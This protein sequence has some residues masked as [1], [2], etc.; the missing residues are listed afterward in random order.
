MEKIAVADHRILRA[1]GK[2]VGGIGT[3]MAEHPIL[4]LNAIVLPI[5]AAKLYSD[6]ATGIGRYHADIE[7]NN[8][9]RQNLAMQQQMINQDQ[10][11]S[12]PIRRNLIMQPTLM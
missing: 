8:L 11:T 12:N 10:P 6:Y 7:R 3:A 9:I 4:T 5:V 2:T 1:F